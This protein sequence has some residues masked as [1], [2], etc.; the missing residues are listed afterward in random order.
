MKNPFQ[1]ARFFDLR[2]RYDVEPPT[3]ERRY[4]AGPATTQVDDSRESGVSVYSSSMQV[5]N[6]VPVFVSTPAVPAMTGENAHSMNESRM[7]P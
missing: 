4:S 3:F 6:A 1:K 5:A 7:E 2:K